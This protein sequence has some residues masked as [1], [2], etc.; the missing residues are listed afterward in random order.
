VAVDMLLER[1]TGGRSAAK[2]RRVK[3][4]PEL[5]VREST[6]RSVD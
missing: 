3:L 5:R 2:P 1:L 4:A 6:A